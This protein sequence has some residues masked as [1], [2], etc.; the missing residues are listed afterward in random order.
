MSQSLSQPTLPELLPLSEADKL[1]A[2]CISTDLFQL[3]F[4][5]SPELA[6]LLRN[7]YNGEASESVSPQVKAV[8][9]ATLANGALNTCNT[10]LVESL[11]HRAKKEAAICDDEGSP[12]MTHL[13]LLL[14]TYQNNIGRPHSS[15]L[16]T[17]A[18]SRKLFAMGLH[19]YGPEGNDRPDLIQ[20]RRI[21]AWSVYYH[22]TKDF[23]DPCA[24]EPDGLIP[25]LP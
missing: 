20:K 19:S 17:G 8:V 13:S 24:N 18:A 11:F 5:L 22:E 23:H 2:H 1:L 15:Y 25:L 21:I 16:Y 6:D 9:L 3:P 4:F 10:Y 12:T 7:V 14:A